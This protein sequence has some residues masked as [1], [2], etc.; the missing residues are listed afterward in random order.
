MSLSQPLVEPYQKQYADQGF[1]RSGL[2]AFIQKAYHPVE[3]LYPGEYPELD[4]AGAELRAG[5]PR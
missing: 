4:Q 5:N 3:V 2:Y 1:E